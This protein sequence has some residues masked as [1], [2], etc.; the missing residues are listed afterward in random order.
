VARQYFQLTDDLHLPGRWHLATPCSAIGVELE[1][2]WRLRAGH[3][4]HVEGPLQAPIDEP[5]TPLDF[6][7]AGLSIPVISARLV[8]LFTQL[9][10]GDAQLLPVKVGPLSEPYRILVATQLI[11]CIDDQRTAEVRYWLPEHG[12]PDKVGQYR[13]LWDMR[14]DPSKVGKAQLFR[15]WGWDQALIISD[16]LKAALERAGATGVKFTEV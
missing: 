4:V 12:Q 5:G 7:L 6:T 1:D 15:T 8:P 9:A 11:R 16:E 14:I 2:P 13:D 3:P 10:Q